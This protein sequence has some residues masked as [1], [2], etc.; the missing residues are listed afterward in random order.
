V[1]NCFTDFT[2]LFI[3]SSTERKDHRV[4][5]ILKK[6][7]LKLL[8]LLLLLRT[9]PVI[10]Y[11]YIREA[12]CT[13]LFLDNKQRTGV[14]LTVVKNVALVRKIF[15]ANEMSISSRLINK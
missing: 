10:T 5:R 6:Q 11:N 2:D 12:H 7:F 14:Q 13:E 4:I 8:K 15:C 3:L 9:M 1:T